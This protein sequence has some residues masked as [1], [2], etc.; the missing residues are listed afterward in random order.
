MLLCPMI[1]VE[2]IFG[3]KYQGSQQT[4]T[5]FVALTKNFFTDFYFMGVSFPDIYL[6]GTIFPDHDQNPV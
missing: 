4:I 3:I 2:T 6:N 5:G 1:I